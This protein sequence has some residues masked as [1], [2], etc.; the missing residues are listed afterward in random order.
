MRGFDEPARELIAHRTRGDKDAPRLDVAVARRVLR[1]L[2][3]LMEDLLGDGL[4]EEPSDRAPVPHRF[5]KIHGRE[6]SR[7]ELFHGAAL[8]RAAR[9]MA[10]RE[11]PR[12]ASMGAIRGKCW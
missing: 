2:K 5:I 1:E 9:L 4:W 11:P 3:D 7:F 8:A 10:L 6:H 12:S